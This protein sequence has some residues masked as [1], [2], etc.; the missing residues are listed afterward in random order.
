LEATR[1]LSL[2]RQKFVKTNQVAAATAIANVAGTAIA[3]RVAGA[4]KVA[5]VRAVAMAIEGTAARR[6]QKNAW[7]VLM[8]RR[9]KALKH[10]ESQARGASVA[11]ADVVAKA[12]ERSLAIETN[13]V[14]MVVARRNENLVA[15]SFLLKT[16]QW[17]QQRVQCLVTRKPEAH[18]VAA[19]IA[20]HATAINDDAARARTTPVCCP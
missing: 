14:A 3:I 9:R 11:I 17:P 1:K 7:N 12:L 13:N 4:S 6:A 16:M 2:P 15:K 20:G 18:S 8:H 5:A 19:A 10:Q